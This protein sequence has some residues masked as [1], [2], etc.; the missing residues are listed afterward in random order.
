MLELDPK[1][2]QHLRGET[3]RRRNDHIPSDEEDG[4]GYTE[5]RASELRQLTIADNTL[6]RFVLEGPI[7]HHNELTYDAMF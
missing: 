6:S 3:H 5:D 1:Q 4:P 7:I 2:C